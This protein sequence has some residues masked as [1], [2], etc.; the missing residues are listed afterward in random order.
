MQL[1]SQ[2]YA[3][4]VSCCGSSLI[5]LTFDLFS[6]AVLQGQVRLVAFLSDIF[7]SRVDMFNDRVTEFK[8]IVFSVGHC[9]LILRYYLSV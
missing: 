3:I 1:A 2:E 6:L 8:K 7:Q 5:D 4:V 9:L